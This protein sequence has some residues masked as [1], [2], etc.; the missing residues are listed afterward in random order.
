MNGCME[1][2]KS[3]PWWDRTMQGYVSQ[4]DKETARRH[5]FGPFIRQ[6]V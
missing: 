4:Y 5:S 2:S 3:R 1:V 6:I